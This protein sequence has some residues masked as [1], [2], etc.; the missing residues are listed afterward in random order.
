MKFTSLLRAAQQAVY[1]QYRLLLWRLNGMLRQSALISTSQGK[2]KVV[3]LKKESIGRS[4]YV[5]GQYEMDLIS[6]VLNFL[7]DSERLP[8]AGGILLD[9]GAN[10]GVIS[11]G[12]LRMGKF[13][14]AIAFEPAPENFSLLEYNVALNGLKDRFLCLPYAVADAPS[15]LRFELSADNYGDHRVRAA[16][17]GNGL[18]NE[19]KRREIIVKAQTLDALLSSAPAAF[20]KPASLVWLDVQGYE[21]YVFKGGRK[22]FGSGVPV[23][24]EIWPY[25]IQRAGMTA[26][27]FCEIAASLW[28][29][30][31][32]RRRG[33]F[34]QYPIETLGAVFE[35]L[36]FDGA[37]DNLIFMGN[38]HAA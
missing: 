27:Q 11:I 28:T 2:F 13:E 25:G 29:H 20:S 19:S 34:I 26:P 18:Q 31:W 30:Y 3:F 32:I 36:G 23:V 14:R 10:N 33:K 5:S 21:G 7:R 8:M 24:A 6:G 16:N 35:E 1:S 22:L 17:M 9:V 4:L 15:E 37:Y 12:L 38:V